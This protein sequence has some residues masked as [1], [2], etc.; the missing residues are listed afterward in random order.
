MTDRRTRI[1]DYFVR[2][3][4]THEGTVAENIESLFSPDLV[5]HLTGDKTMNRDALIKVSELLRRLRHDQATMVTQFT[6]D[7]DDVSFVLYIVGR[8]PITGHEVSVSTKTEYRF[9]G[10][11]VVE[12]WQENPEAL[13]AAVRAA[14]VRP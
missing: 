7:G 1:A 10:D 4:E 2:Q 11:R 6:E 3:Y 5:F 13:E 9:E 14:G 8:D 12:V